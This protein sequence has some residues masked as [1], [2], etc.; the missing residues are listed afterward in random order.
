MAS[1]SDGASAEFW[2]GLAADKEK[3]RVDPRFFAA[4]TGGADQVDGIQAPAGMVKELQA[5]LRELHG[6]ADIPDPYETVYK[7]W[8]GD[9]FGGGW[10]FWKIGQDPDQV[11]PRIQHPVPD[12]KVYICGEAWSH[13]QGWVEGALETADAVLAEHLGVAA[14]PW[15]AP[16]PPRLMGVAGA[17]GAAEPVMPVPPDRRFALQGAH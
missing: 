1:Y 13:Q 11:M 8:A 15:V 9:P 14:P 6:L 12:A 10:H 17:E 4:V 3:H 2:A 7:D 16:P 5:Q